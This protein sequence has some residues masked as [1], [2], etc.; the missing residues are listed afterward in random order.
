MVVRQDVTHADFGYLWALISFVPDTC[1]VRHKMLYASTRDNLKKQLGYSYFTRE[2]HATTRAEL[3]FDTYEAQGARVNLDD[4][5]TM[6][7]KEKKEEA[8][9]HVHMGATRAGVHGVDFPMTPA[10]TAKV[11]AFAGGAINYLQ[12]RL[13]IDSENIDLSEAGDCDAAGL[14]AHVPADEPR[15]HVF[16]YEHSHEGQ[17]IAPILFVYSC[18]LN[19]K[20]KHRMLTSSCKVACL[21]QLEEAGVVCEKKLEIT[22]PDD[23]TGEV[24]HST[25]HPPVWDNAKHNFAKPAATAARGGRR[26]PVRSSR[27]GSA[28]GGADDD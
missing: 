2:L 7:E 17:N 24:V 3:T 12:L 14:A 23:L 26:R 19:S 5:L 1:P 20:I 22:E 4:V 9:Q 16:R 15:Y 18:P 10:A 28:A 13:N 6:A 11:T 27:G 8:L 21:K 25:F